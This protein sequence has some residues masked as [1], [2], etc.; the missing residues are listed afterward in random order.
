MTRA[1][2]S[3]SSQWQPRAALIVAC[4]CAIAALTTGVVW[5]RSSG[6]LGDA[7]T[8][9]PTTRPT[10]SA[11]QCVVDR[12]AE[13][14]VN[15]EISDEATAELL[16]DGAAI[17]EFNLTPRQSP[18]Q[19]RAKLHGTRLVI[20]KGYL[21]TPTALASDIALEVKDKSELPDEVKRRLTPADNDTIKRAN[22]T[23]GRW[24][25]TSLMTSGSEPFGVIVLWREAD[26]SAAASATRSE[27][28]RVGE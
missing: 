9:Q 28:R 17:R 26:G 13:A 25:A 22:S 2:G 15:A 19:F 21:E 5:P 11:W 20:A 1:G 6:E 16:T 23:A 14:L 8:T 24:I 7:A 27:E 18:E 10:R 3:S 12:F 4:A